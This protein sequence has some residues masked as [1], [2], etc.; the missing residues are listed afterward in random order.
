MPRIVFIVTTSDKYSLISIPYIYG[1]P[2][3]YCHMNNGFWRIPVTFSGTT[4]AW[5]SLDG[6]P[7]YQ[8]N[9]QDIIYNYVALG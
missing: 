7:V 3:F 8:F 2:R 1:T 4:I 9:E 6:T 5:Y